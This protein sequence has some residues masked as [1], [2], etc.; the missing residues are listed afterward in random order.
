MGKRWQRVSLM[1][2]EGVNQ[3]VKDHGLKITG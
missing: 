2:G 3:R 1:L